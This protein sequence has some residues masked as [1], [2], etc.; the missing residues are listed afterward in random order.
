MRY[1]IL[2]NSICILFYIGSYYFKDHLSYFL[3]EM[4][5][6]HPFKKICL[7]FFVLDTFYYRPKVILFLKTHGFLW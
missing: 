6:P 7:V 5:E 1:V 3:I 4:L 2:S